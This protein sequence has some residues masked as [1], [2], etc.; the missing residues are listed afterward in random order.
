MTSILTLLLLAQQP[1]PTTL[2]RYDIHRTPTPLTIDGRLDEPAWRRATPIDFVFPWPSQT[3]APQ[4][5]RARLLWDDTYL[6]IA[7]ECVDT[8]ITATYIWRDDPTYKDDAVEV[9]LNP[10][11]SQSTAYIGLEMNA[12]GTLYDYLMLA[13]RGLFAQLQLSGVRLA[14][15][16]S[17]TLNVPSDRDTGWTLELAIPFAAFESLAPSKPPKTGTEWRLNLNR[18]D[19]TEPHRRLSQWTPSGLPTPNPHN[20]ASFG[21]V[22]FVD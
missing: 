20:I 2:P 17:G 5:T 21:R 10:D 11:P 7:Y 8:D 15:T 16:L 6:Y 1:T 3:G 19:G 9:F 13:G 12:R 14:T 4:P 22:F 18:W